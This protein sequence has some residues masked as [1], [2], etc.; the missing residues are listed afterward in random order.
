MI[1]RLGISTTYR[2]MLFLRGFRIRPVDYWFFKGYYPFLNFFAKR[3]FAVNPYLIIPK[4]IFPLFHHSN[5]PIGAKPLCSKI[6]ILI[7]S[8]Q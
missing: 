1:Q 3:N 5:I 4:P 7:F 2:N 6:N 8:I